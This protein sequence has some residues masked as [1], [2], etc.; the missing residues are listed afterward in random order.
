MI[1]P[2]H[3]FPARMAPDLALQELRT[4]PPQS[5]VL[6]PMAGSGTVLRHA[7]ELG[8][9]ALGFDMD[10]LAVLMSR[11]WVTPVD[12]QAIGAQLK[13]AL[14]E[15][16]AL[17][18][19]DP[20][21]PWID[22]DSET[23]AFVRYWF[24]SRQRADL[25][26]LAYVLARRSRKS[27]VARD[28]LR[29]ALS[30]IIITKDYGASLARDVSHSRPHKVASVSTYDV[31]EGFARAVTVL[32]RSLALAPPPGR[33]SVLRGDA[34]GLHSVG[35]HSVDAVLTSPP[36]L[37][38]IDYLRG[39]RMALV[40]MG[41]TVSELRAIRGHSIGAERAGTAESARLFD[42]IV[43][44]MVVPGR[45]TTR[46]AGMVTRYAYD[47]Y[48]VMSEI[49]RVLKVQGR[50]V[51]VVGNSCLTDVFV[52]NARG[53]AKAGEMVGLRLDRK[54][55][56]WLPVRRRYLPIP[57]ASAAPLG[58]RMRTETILSFVKE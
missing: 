19:R 6:D 21:L 53:V 24:A 32:R 52:R 23:S 40:W 4:L 36:Y 2:V 50:A 35:N 10:P 48:R 17:G 57:R 29:L 11:V 18:R 15:V 28:V 9:V 14:T 38:A 31:Q 46:H 33:A 41:H 51:L 12:D 7:A 5:R 20:D 16:R 44:A 34:R 56:R 1:S 43:R 30:R 37:N 3:P 58:R 49:A 47:V 45:L 54:V 27:E 39:H 55:E 8:H 22:D 26:R 13:W 42:E 25:R